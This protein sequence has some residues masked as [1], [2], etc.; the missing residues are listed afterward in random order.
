LILYF[1]F[2]S[3]EYKGA[4]SRRANPAARRRSVPAAQRRRVSASPESSALAVACRDLGHAKGTRAHATS[5]QRSYL[6]PRPCP[7]TIAFP[8]EPPSHALALL[9][10]P[11]AAHY[12]TGHEQWLATAA[13]CH[14]HNMFDDMLERPQGQS[15]GLTRA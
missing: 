3:V 10:P 13:T 1:Y 12:T 5:G 7:T 2:L 6:W 15:L 11:L 8:L 9:V 4:T 14:A